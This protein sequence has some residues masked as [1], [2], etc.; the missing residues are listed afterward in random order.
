[1][2]DSSTLIAYHS[3]HEATHTLAHHLL[4]RIEHDHDPLH[5]YYSVMSAMELLIRPIR[6]GLQE[7]TFMHTFL[8]A[9]PNLT[10]LPM[11]LT[12]AL[13]AANVRA[14]TNIRTPDA[15]IIASA[16]LA[17]CEAIVCNDQQWIGRLRGL[18]PQFSWIYLG[19]FAP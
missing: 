6:T 16:L 18:F 17:G 15:V 9:Y 3:P 10:A 7:F 14:T 13:Q 12:V 5:G 1:M 2:L 4:R 19:Q 8:S 11:D